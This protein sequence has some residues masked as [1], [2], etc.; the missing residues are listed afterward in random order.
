[1][2]SLQSYH[3]RVSLEELAV[4][5]SLTGHPA[6]AK[7]ILVASLGE[8]NP[9]EEKGRL[10]AANHTLM[11]KDILTIQ[12]AQPVLDAQVVRLVSVL[13][14]Q[15]FLL[16]LSSGEG[17]S[18]RIL[19]YYFQD[20][21]VVEHQV[22]FGVVHLFEEVENAGVIS[23]RAGS[24]LSLD[25]VAPFSVTEFSVAQHEMDQVRIEALQ[26]TSAAITRLQKLGVSDHASKLLVE[27]I[28]SSK[29]RGALV[30]VDFTNDG[31]P[32]SSRGSLVLKGVSGRAWLMDIHVDK[33]GPNLI[34][35]PYSVRDFENMIFKLVKE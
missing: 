12:D 31:L 6:I 2:T 33:N 3:L 13:S 21:L 28:S 4:L 34:V 35:R 14:K 20:D 32:R 7:N 24:F 9:D 5:L 17:I 1:M 29:L 16:R 25:S 11:A 19:T 8:M 30:R 15:N 27:D 23:V 10:L 18:E 26:S 22:H